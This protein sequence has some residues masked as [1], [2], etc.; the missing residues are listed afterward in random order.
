MH[1]T[2]QTIQ[3]CAD[4]CSGEGPAC[5]AFNFDTADCSC[6]TF[7][8]YT[9]TGVG[10]CYTKQ[11]PVAQPQITTSAPV[12]QP[13]ITTS[14]PVVQ[15]PQISTS[16]PVAQPDITT[17]APAAAQPDIT[18][19]APVTDVTT[20]TAGSHQEAT[21]TPVFSG[22]TVAPA[23]GTNGSRQNVAAKSKSSNSLAWSSGGGKAFWIVMMAL[24][25][26]TTGGV[27][28]AMY[29]RKNKLRGAYP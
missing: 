10:V 6:V 28:F 12:A 17:S 15:Q 4:L 3:G 16:A 25:T 18:T 7:A 19:S 14:A 20:G 2:N 9:D 24:L 5:Q 21:G 1:H 26:V 23:N 22:P 27:V 11:A 13:Q 29:R 8:S